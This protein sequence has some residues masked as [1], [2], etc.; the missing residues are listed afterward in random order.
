MRVL[1]IFLI[2]EIVLRIAY[3]LWL[4]KRDFPIHTIGQYE[5]SQ[6]CQVES[7]SSALAGLISAARVKVGIW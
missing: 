3:G 2:I 1:L 7:L 6:R 5:P 4:V